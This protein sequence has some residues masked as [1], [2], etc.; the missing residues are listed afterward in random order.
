MITEES[1]TLLY[2]AI[3]VYNR[4]ADKDYLLA[5][6]ISKNQPIEYLILRINRHNFWHLLGCKTI[7]TDTSNSPA[8]IDLYAE[9]LRKH[10]I[11][12]YLVYTHTAQDLKA[13]YNVFM[14]I[15]DF[16]AN[17]KAVR[18]CK[19]DST[20]EYYQF[21]IAVGQHTGII[22]Y[23]YEN[24]SLSILFPKTA[25]N[26]SIGNFD[27]DRSAKRILYI[28]S[29]PITNSSFDRIEYAPSESV[30]KKIILELPDAYDSTIRT[31]Y[32][33]ENNI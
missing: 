21:K 12:E 13:K 11:A 24:Q 22:G 4:L 25:Q 27:N 7:K 6:N 18:I 29:K 15:F 16:I 20:P 33:E 32:K 2:K 26:K 1:M 8:D 3:E 31:Q 14:N 10:N 30:F 9:C 19:T 17:A 23:D 28:L 5:C